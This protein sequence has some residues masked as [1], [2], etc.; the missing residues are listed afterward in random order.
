MSR[1]NL[2]TRMA[3]TVLGVVALVM[4]FSMFYPQYQEYLELQRRQA[5]L[6]M[7]LQLEQEKLKFLKHNQERMQTDPGFVERVA[8]EELGF[9]RPGE[10]VIKFVDEERATVSTQP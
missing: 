7:E 10:T 1:L 5:A 3:W 4:I 6:E 9:A 2:L 8:R